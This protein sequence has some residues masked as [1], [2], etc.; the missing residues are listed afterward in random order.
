MSNPKDHLPTIRALA[1]RLAACKPTTDD[2]IA[3]LG[4]I[5]GAL[6]ALERA[7]GLGYDDSRSAPV[8]MSFAGDFAATL[9]AIG[10][11]AAHPQAWQSGFFFNSAIMRLAALN[12]RLPANDV[13]KGIRRSVNLLKHHADAHISGKRPVTFLEAVTAAEDLSAV[14]EASM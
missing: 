12:E 3:G 9:A 13:A 7:A 6:Y 11:G 2:H 14:I 10:K 8:P 5:A 4:F 1:K